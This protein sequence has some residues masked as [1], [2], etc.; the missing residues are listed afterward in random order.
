MDRFFVS[1][2]ITPFRYDKKGIG[3]EKEVNKAEL[4]FVCVNTPYKKEV[5]NI[6]LSFIL[7]VVSLIDGEKIVV[8]RSTV[9]PGTTDSLQKKFSQHRFL[10][11]PEF[12]R[13]KTAHE[14]FIKPP[15]QIIGYTEKSREEAE[16][17]LALLPKAPAEYTKILPVKAA[18]MVK[19]AANAMLA[20]K[21]SSANKIFDF[22]NA[23]EIDYKDIKEL[24]GA[25]PRI[26]H[27][28]LDVWY[29]DFRGYNGT[30]FP[31]DVRT[32]ISVGEKFG[33]DVDWFR[34]MDDDN[35]RLLANQRLKPDY[36]YPKKTV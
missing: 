2:G 7:S 4:I 3:S 30:C 12:L 29:E 1:R 31:K 24:I 10:F 36:G 5:D 11:N 16:K 26:G 22:C 15:R 20:I 33:V 21:V 25:D 8:I 34:A 17:V 6:D 14:D 13:A 32:L 35:L 28:G 18:E 19:Y 9:P 23:F 27:W